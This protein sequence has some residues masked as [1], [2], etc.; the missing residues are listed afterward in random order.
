MPSEA[1]FEPRSPRYSPFLVLWMTQIAHI[2]GQFFA[3][4]GP[5]IGHTV[6]LEGNKRLFVTGKSS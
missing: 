1:S 4:F 3:I 5:L 6:E 2:P